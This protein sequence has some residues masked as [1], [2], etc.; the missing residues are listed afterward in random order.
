MGMASNRKPE[1]GAPGAVMESRGN[2]PSVS[3]VA[4]LNEAGDNFKEGKLPIFLFSILL[5]TGSSLYIL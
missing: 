1:N 3:Q 5:Q 4:K 2:A